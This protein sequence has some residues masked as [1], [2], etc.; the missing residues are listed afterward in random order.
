MRREF[1][2]TVGILT[3]AFGVGILLSFVLPGRLLAFVLAVL[4]LSASIMLLR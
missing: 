2:Q 4:L 3:L 1:R